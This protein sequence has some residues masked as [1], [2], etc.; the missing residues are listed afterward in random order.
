MTME[1]YAKFEE[2]LPFQN[3]HKEIDEFWLEHSKISKLCTLMGSFWSNYIM[4]ALKKHREV[5]FDGTEDYFKIW[6][7]TDL[8]F[9]KWLE[10]F[11][12]FSPGHSK[13]SKLGLW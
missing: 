4:F 11:R 3:W 9:K 2:E 1:N 8:H 10:E 13:I 7:K 12:T 6:R 5:I